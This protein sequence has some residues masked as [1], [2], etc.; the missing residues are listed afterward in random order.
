M[1]LRPRVE[2]TYDDLDWWN[3]AAHPS[4]SRL[5]WA[6]VALNAFYL[7]LGIAGLWLRPRFAGWMLIYF[8][9]RSCLLATIE[10]PE[11]RYTLEC[12][13]MLF[14]LGGVAVHGVFTRTAAFR[15]ART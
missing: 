8:A 3:Y 4:E 10:A 6:C 13:P 5:S 9:L 2:R 7:L 11:A 12:F 14:V 1:W 15:L